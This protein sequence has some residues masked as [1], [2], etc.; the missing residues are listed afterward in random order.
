MFLAGLSP[1]EDAGV[2]E[3]STNA[4]E[5]CDVSLRRRGVPPCQFATGCNRAFAAME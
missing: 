2:A 1:L 5:N 4:I 3:K